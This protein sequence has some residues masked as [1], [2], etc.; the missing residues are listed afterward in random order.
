MRPYEGKTNAIIIDHAGAVYQHGFIDE[1]K[2]WSL[3]GND[4]IQD[5]IARLK[6]K[7]GEPSFQTCKECFA[8][9]T[10]KD[11]C[12]VCGW[13]VPRKAKPVSFID[14]K[15]GKIDRTGATIF[16][17][18]SGAKEDVIAELLTIQRAKGFKEGWVGFNFKD[19]F[20]HWPKSLNFT[21]KEPSSE[22][23]A[24]LQK[25]HNQFINQKRRR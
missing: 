7:Q 24:W 19:M 22:T 23:L 4:K 21:S 17:P 18:P 10:K 15:L 5:R 8:V 13:C 12:P 14:G 1:P 2:E 25:K 6:E 9:F 16:M 20:G 11:K 3:D